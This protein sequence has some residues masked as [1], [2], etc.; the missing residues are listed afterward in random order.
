MTRN[1]V[2]D[3]QM[4]IRWQVTRAPI[5]W[6]ITWKVWSW[7]HGSLI[8]SRL[9]A[10][11]GA[12]DSWEK[13]YC[14]DCEGELLGRWSSW[15]LAYH[16]NEIGNEHTSSMRS[17]ITN[18]TWNP[19]SYK[20]SPRSSQK[21]SLRTPLHRQLC[22][23][24]SSTHEPDVKT[25]SLPLSLDNCGGWGIQGTWYREVE[26]SKAGD[27][28]DVNVLSYGCVLGKFVL[29]RISAEHLV[30]VLLWR[31]ILPRENWGQW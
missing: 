2:L 27:G 24:C 10:G 5:M 31:W 9:D 1:K 21:P 29:A 28:W 12:H 4:F 20:S 17:A 13:C 19:K 16:Q 7:Q 15:V 6:M 14:K 11:Q 8:A 26:I 22:I 30:S 18:Y 23:L 3:G 25:R